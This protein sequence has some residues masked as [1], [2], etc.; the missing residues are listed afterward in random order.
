MSRILNTFEKAFGYESRRHHPY[1][2]NYVK[3]NTR[4]WIAYV[5]VLGQITYCVQLVWLFQNH[6]NAKVTPGSTEWAARFVRSLLVVSV[7]FVVVV[8]ILDVIGTVLIHLHPKKDNIE[9]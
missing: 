7:V 8:I 6:V 9:A 3:Q 5:P 4:T 1:N 2:A